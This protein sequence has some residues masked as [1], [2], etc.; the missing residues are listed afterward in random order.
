LDNADTA[1]KRDLLK[2]LSD[3]FAWSE[4]VSAGTL[5]LLQKDGTTMECSLV[6]MSECKAKLPELLA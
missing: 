6:L 4:T 5:Q 1:Y 2:L 3:N